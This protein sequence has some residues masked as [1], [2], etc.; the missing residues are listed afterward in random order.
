M[1]NGLINQ[2]NSFAYCMPESFLRLQTSVKSISGNICA[3][4]HIDLIVSTMPLHEPVFVNMLAINKNSS[5]SSQPWLGILY[6]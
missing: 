1:F 5:G 3:I 2:I 4:F 6:K